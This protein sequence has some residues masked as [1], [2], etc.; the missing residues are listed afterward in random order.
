MYK[1]SNV[2]N[3]NGKDCRIIIVPTLPE[4]NDICNFPSTH[5]PKFKK[6]FQGETLYFCTDESNNFKCCKD[7]PSEIT[8]NL[9]MEDFEL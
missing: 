9:F 6:K 5:V 7:I 8:S 4:L 1:K 3:Q 2:F